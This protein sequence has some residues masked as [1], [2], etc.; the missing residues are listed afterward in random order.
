MAK[1]QPNKMEEVRL[2]LNKL[3]VQYVITKDESLTALIND[4]Q[5]KLDY[6]YYGI[7]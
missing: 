5:A 2:E 7:K 6:F 3:I 1:V 4:L